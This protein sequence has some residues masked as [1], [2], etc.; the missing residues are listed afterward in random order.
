M[1]FEEKVSVEKKGK[2]PSFGFPPA[3]CR[4]G[5]TAVLSL[6]TTTNKNTGERKQGPASSFCGRDNSN[7]PTWELLDWYQFQQWDSFCPACWNGDSQ[8][9]FR[10]YTDEQVRKAWR[11]LMGEVSAESDTGSMAA[12]FPRLHLSSDH[13]DKAIEI[14]NYEAFRNN[15]PESLPAKYKLHEVWG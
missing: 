15:S 13:M 9:G 8:P 10:K 5:K 2:G 4:C 3:S 14:V 7:N 12:V 6:L 11:W 1:A